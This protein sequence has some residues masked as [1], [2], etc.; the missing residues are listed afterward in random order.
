MSGAG[1]STIGVLLAKALGYDFIDTDLMIQHREGL[2][3]QELLDQKGIEAFVEAEEA[4]VKSMN[5]TG[6][7]IISTGGSVVYGAETMTFLKEQGQIVYLEVSHSEL[8][9]R[10]NDITT[11]GIVKRP[12][13]TFEEVYEE[14]IH[15]YETYAEVTMDC[16][17]RSIEELVTAL[18]SR[19]RG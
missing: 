17:E 9:K 16:N 2:L 18:H 6:H 15:L 8:I 13:Q 19:I 10:L 14:R 1:K 5:L 7:T 4:A 11:R 12:N 3:L